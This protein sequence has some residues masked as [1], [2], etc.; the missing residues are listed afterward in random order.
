[1]EMPKPT[2]DH[3]KLQKLAGQWIGK[4]KMHPSPWDPQGGEAVGKV[5]NRVA[6]DG[7]V[8]IQDYEQERGG[9][10]NFRG[11][12]VFR[13]D[14]AEKGYVLH[15][16]DSMGMP[17]NI[18]RGDFEG[19]L[20]KLNCDDPQFKSRVTWNLVRPDRYSYKMEVSPDGNQWFPFMEAE[21]EKKAS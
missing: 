9:K 18:F 13:F 4:E 10:V 16:W 12:G 7:F 17:P 6:L 21:Y 3:R 2:E 11:H 1:M 8:V 19:D 14:A 15:W 5:H 20:L